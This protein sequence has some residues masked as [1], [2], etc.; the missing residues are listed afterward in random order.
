MLFIYFAILLGFLS[1]KTNE[2]HALNVKEATIINIGLRH[3][4][5]TC[6]LLFSER[7]ALIGNM[8]WHINNVTVNLQFLGPILRNMVVESDVHFHNRAFLID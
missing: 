1:S 3:F 5:L 7:D 8:T 2:V 6:V 4:V